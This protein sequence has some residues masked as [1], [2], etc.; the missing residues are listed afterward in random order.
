MCVNRTST[1]RDRLLGGK[2][3]DSA[4]S[5]RVKGAPQIVIVLLGALL[6]A[7]CGQATAE[8]ECMNTE[9]LARFESVAETLR[10]ELK[11]PAISAAIVHEGELVWSRGFGISDLESGTKATPQT[12]YGLASVTQPFAAS[13]L[14]RLVE[15]GRLDL[16]APITDFGFDLGDDRITTRHLL[17]HTSYGVAGR[18]FRFYG[19]R[20]ARLTDII[21]H[22]YE[23][24]Y[25]RILR[26]EILEP[27]GMSDTALNIGGC[28]V[29]YYMSTLSD[30]D[31]ER[32]F[33]H[34]Y[35]HLATPYQYDP[36]YEVFPA[37][38]PTYAT[39]AAGLISTVED[40]AR[41]AIAIEQ[42]ELVSAESKAAMFTP[43]RLTNGE[44]GLGGLGWLVET[45]DGTKLVWHFGN[46]AYSSLVLIVP[47]KRL[48]LI[49]LGNTPN[50]TRPFGL[51]WGD[52][53][54]MISPFALEFYKQFV[55]QPDADEDLPR[56]DW[57][58][59]EDAIAGQLEQIGDETLLGL[60]E[61]E[62]WSYRKLFAGAGDY[63]QARTL[64]D[65][66]TRVFPD[67]EQSQRDIYMARRPTE[68][69]IER[70]RYELAD[71]EQLS[72]IGDYRLQPEDDASDLP[73]EIE[74]RVLAGRVLAIP[75][76]AECQEYYPLGPSRLV[77]TNSAEI[78]MVGKLGEEP[79]GSFELRVSGRTIATYERIE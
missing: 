2:L 26:Q 35:E 73:E 39:A 59:D 77:A 29:E 7:G 67:A 17:S 74:I 65:V 78:L 1:R 15:D 27:L 34:V 13:L 46:G 31:P 62:L 51:G 58:G 70:E 45:F 24:S 30:D 16:D 56:I 49:V 61:N 6:L 14:M 12:P 57:S 28:G 55:L 22:F 8:R 69:P 75:S 38:V 25:R 21:E 4:L 50:L 36:D 66:H 71:N 60:Y 18:D 52:V 33:R 40:L 43:T 11:I 19:A 32:A 53:S 10:V 42:D 48:T 54:V 79:F 68:Q 76:N 63:V 44:N 20:Y 37:L 41:F 47:D 3:H 5:S 72:W 23:T 64:L 9:S